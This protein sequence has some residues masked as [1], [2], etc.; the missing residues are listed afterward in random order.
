MRASIQIPSS[1]KSLLQQRAY[2][3]VICGSQHANSQKG[4]MKYYRDSNDIMNPAL[5][6]PPR[7]WPVEVFV[8][9]EGFPIA[10][11]IRQFMERAYRVS[12]SDVRL[13]I[14]PE[15]H[16][17]GAM[18]FAWGSDIFFAP[19][20]YCPATVKWRLL[21]A[22]E[23][24]H[25]IQQREGRVSNLFSLRARSG[26]RSIFGNGGRQGGLCGMGLRG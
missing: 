11:D 3:I 12:F 17:I 23:L 20:A 14:G 19:D 8:Q 2:C 4:H 9:S 10:S 22:H 24:A 6:N 18:A 7:V 21:L 25:I 13:H 5:P 16:A 26:K 1:I 15:A